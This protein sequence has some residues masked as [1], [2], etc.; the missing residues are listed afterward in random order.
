VNRTFETALAEVCHREQV[1]LLAYSALAFGH[2]TG[3]YLAN[4]AAPGRLTQWPAFGQRYGKPNVIPA[5]TAYAA[6]AKKHGLTLTQMAPGFVRSRWF[7]SSTIVGASSL[8]Q[9]RETL[10]ATRTPIDAGLLAEIDAIHLRYTNP[11]P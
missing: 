5:V 7:V 4:P 3:K 2:L 9:L 6:L 8:A 10:P 11:A 1:G